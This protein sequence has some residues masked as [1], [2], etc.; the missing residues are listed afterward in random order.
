MVSIKFCGAAKT[1]TG[2]NYLVKTEHGNFLVDCGMFQGPEVEH[3]NLEE[4]DYDPKEVDFAFLTH[5]HI[6]HSGMLPKLYVKGFRGPI[7]ATNHTILLATELLMDSA[8]IQENNF[9]RGQN[10]G[11]F[12]DKVAL[13][14]N[15]YDSEQTLSQFKAIAFGSEFSPVEGIKVKFHRAGHILGAVSI[16][17]DIQDSSGDKKILFSGDIGRTQD[18]LIDSFDLAYRSNPDYI[19]M[20]SLYGGEIHPSESESMDKLL[21]VIDKTIER[22]G[23]VFIPVFALQRTQLL[24]NDL[25]KAKLSGKLKKETPVFLDSPLAQRITN[26]YMSS[27]Q[28]T[29]ESMFDFPNLTYIRKYRQ[30]MQLTNRT[31]QVILAGSGMADGGR[32]MEHLVK[33]LQN[34]KNSVAFVGYQAEGTLGREL[35]DGSK[36]VLIGGR[37]IDVRAEID[38]YSGFSAHGDSNDYLTWLNSYHTENLKKIFLIHA[39]PERSEKL[40]QQIK[41]KY[42]FEN[43][44]IPSMQEEV[45]LN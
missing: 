2:S 16:E 27:L 40:R 30:S 44:H 8:K 43:C 36:S 13:I 18:A 31:R 1:V 28:S 23:N 34:K 10:Y 19:V 24:L 6:D 35:V 7:Y 21:E 12:T 3:L 9:K 41:D 29:E 22:G 38:Y 26:I 20:E 42:S 17:I 39:E 5:A 11:K 33:G 15:S 14:F 32:I 25:R 45:V 37:H 4:Y